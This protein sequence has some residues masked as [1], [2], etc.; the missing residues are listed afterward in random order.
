MARADQ[1]DRISHRLTAAALVGLGL[2]SAP[3]WAQSELGTPGGTGFGGPGIGGPGIGI[4]GIG[5]GTMGG[6]PLAGTAAGAALAPMAAPGTSTYSPGPGWDVNLGVTVAGTFTDNSG[7][8][9]NGRGNELTGEFLPFIRINADTPRV[10]GNL[11]YQPAYRFNVNNSR[12]NG[13]S[14]YANGH[15]RAIIVEDLAYVDA[16]AYA[17]LVPQYAGY[18]FGLP[19]NDPNGVPVPGSNAGIS[20]RNLSQ[21]MSFSVAPTVS[22]QFGG[23]GT[24]TASATYSYTSSNANNYGGGAPNGL[25]QAYNNG[26]SEVLTETVQFITGENLGQFQDSISGS[27]SQINGNGASRNGSTMFGRNTLSYA[28]TRW[29][30]L[31][32]SIGYQSANYPNA[33]VV[34]NNTTTGTQRGYKF[35]GMYWNASV[36]VIPNPDS[37][38]TIGYGR[39]WGT[40]QWT[41]QASYAV[42][43]RTT[44]NANYYTTLGTSLYGLQ[45][46]LTTTNPGTPGGPPVIGNGFI[47]GTQNIYRTNT[48][49]IGSNTTWT[50]DSLGIYVSYSNQTTVAT[51]VQPI[52]NVPAEIGG[53][54][55]SLALSANWTH[56]F[57]DV[58]NGTLYGTFGRRIASSTNNGAENFFAASASVRY[59]FS[60][61]LSGTAQYSFYDLASETQNRSY[62]QN[63]ITVS[64]TKQ[65]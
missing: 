18:G 30:S 56:E 6:A 33:I 50:G 9:A 49:A 22:H 58:M 35:D 59:L 45:Q 43:A 46:D 47:P 54:S 29:A 23:W 2:A 41:A 37:Q 12:N 63:L 21:V 34:R 36:K 28:V 40:E 8:T 5:G 53:S 38:I 4:P 11:F 14:Q 42:T 26:R 16:Y 62:M 61:T 64:L 10:S 55:K 52:P 57:S 17:S 44:I 13:F 1:Y 31:M 65:F 19:I 20:R 7:Q 3:A 48:L 27:V 60:P 15:F 39:N 51:A 24:A 25:A 32:G